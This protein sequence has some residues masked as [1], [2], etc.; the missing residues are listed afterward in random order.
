MSR[1]VAFL[2]AYLRECHGFFETLPKATAAL[3]K[4]LK[5]SKGL[6]WY[7]VSRPP[8]EVGKSVTPTS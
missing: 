4:V 1:P 8:R 5:T 2:A 6:R 7:R 3:E